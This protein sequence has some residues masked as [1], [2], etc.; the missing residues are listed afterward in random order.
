MQIRGDFHEKILLTIC[1]LLML[2]PSVCLADGPVIT[3]DSRT[4]DPI[5]GIYD[6]RGNVFVQFP[7]HDTMLT[8]TGDRT[9]VYV[10]AAEVHGQDD[11]T[12]SYGNMN[13]R[14][15]K[16]DVYGT[17]NIAYVSGNINFLQGG[18]SIT[19]D[20][21]SF[22]WDTKLAT[23][24]GNVKVNGAP[25]QGGVTYNVISSKIVS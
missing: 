13:F 12:L 20:N 7:A 24:S 14:C 23:F 19:A 21:G 25:H 2:I 11:I 8:I 22:S 1:M 10:Y 5:R 3:S 4:F 6:L 15:D 9:Q 18:T 17:K 16:V